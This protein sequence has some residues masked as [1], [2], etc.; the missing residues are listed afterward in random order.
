MTTIAD[1]RISQLKVDEA[2]LVKEPLTCKVSANFIWLVHGAIQAMLLAYLPSYA[3]NFSTSAVSGNVASSEKPIVANSSLIVHLSYVSSIVSCAL[4]HHIF[5]PSHM[6]ALVGICLV[7]FFTAAL[8]QI[9]VMWHFETLGTP[10][11]TL[12]RRYAA[13][14]SLGRCI[15]PMIYAHVAKQEDSTNVLFGCVFA[16]LLCAY[17]GVNV[18]ACSMRSW[19]RKREIRELGGEVDGQLQSNNQNRSRRKRKGPYKALLDAGV[20]ES[21]VDIEMDFVIPETSESSEGL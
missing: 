14:S 1:L 4:F 7:G 21:D 3:G 2:K 13:S 20:E 19:S 5:A 12:S 8:P 17:F 18:L 15:G 10:A 6:S 9:I 16:L 11:Y